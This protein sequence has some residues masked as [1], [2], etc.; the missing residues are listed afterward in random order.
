[1][2]YQLLVEHLNTGH[3]GLDGGAV[4]NDLDL[5]ALVHNTALN[6]QSTHAINQKK[7]KKKKKKKKNKF[8]NTTTC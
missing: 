3:S 4:A 7:K 6:L 2:T 8:E 5:V 1:M